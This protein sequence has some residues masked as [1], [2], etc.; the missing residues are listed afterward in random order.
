LLDVALQ[1]RGTWVAHGAEA[2]SG[3]HPR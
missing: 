1:L 3:R 2:V